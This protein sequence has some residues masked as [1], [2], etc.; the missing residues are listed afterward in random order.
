MH[1][2]KRGERTRRSSTSRAVPTVRTCLWP[3]RRNAIVVQF[4]Q[5]KSDSVVSQ[6]GQLLTPPCVLRVVAKQPWFR[7]RES[8]RA[9]RP[10]R[11]PTDPRTLRSSASTSTVAA[12]KGKSPGYSEWLIMCRDIVLCTMLSSYVPRSFLCARTAGSPFPGQN[13]TVYG[14]ERRGPR[15]EI[16]GAGECDPPYSDACITPI[17]VTGDLDCGQLQFQRFRVPPPDPHG[18]DGN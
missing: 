8:Q 6:L 5:W 13:P 16:A 9:H 17:E 18:L 4:D 1:L 11:R 15:A 14:R 2:V 7:W 10:R 3:G 12:R